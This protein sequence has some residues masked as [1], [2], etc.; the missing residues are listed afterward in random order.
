MTESSTPVHAHVLYESMF[1]NTEAIAKAV[2]DGLIEAGCETIVSDVSSEVVGQPTD[3][4]VLV[5]G[6]PTHALSLS[7]PS[8]RKQAVT[9]G[10]PAEREATGVREWLTQVHAA[11]GTTLPQVAAFDTRVD[12]ARRLPGARRTAVRLARRAGFRMLA[13]PEAF[14]VSDNEGPLVDGELDRARRWG[15][16][17]GERVRAHLPAV[18]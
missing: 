7:R 12:K 6:A 9:Q 11:R 17:L 18:S 14:L 1:G 4:D 15:R 13:A 10:A 8:S 16:E 3:A 2:A 5:I